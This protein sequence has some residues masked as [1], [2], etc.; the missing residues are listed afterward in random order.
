LGFLTAII[1]KNT[2]AITIENPAKKNE[3]NPDYQYTGCAGS[4]NKNS[5]LA[6]ELSYWAF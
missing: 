3:K 6:A 1:R 2:I 4:Q 5:G